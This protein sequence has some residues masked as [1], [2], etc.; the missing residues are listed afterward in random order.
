MTLDI[1]SPSN[2]RIIETA[3]LK[4]RRTRDAEGRFLIEGTRETERAVEAIRGAARTGRIGDGKIFVVALERCV[5]IR[6]GEEGH[7]AIG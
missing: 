4:K 1:E 5:R 3:R 6:T 2:R 7:E